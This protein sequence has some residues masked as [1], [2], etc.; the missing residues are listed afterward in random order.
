MHDFTTRLGDV[1]SDSAFLGNFQLAPLLVYIWPPAFKAF[2]R[3]ERN[4]AAIVKI[5]SVCMV[6]LIR[7][8]GSLSLENYGGSV[9]PDDGSIHRRVENHGSIV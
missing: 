4:M 5:F 9:M 2:R 6:V 1:L 7:V 3:I 8:V